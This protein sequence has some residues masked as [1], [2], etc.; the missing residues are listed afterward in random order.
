MLGDDVKE[1]PYLL[2]IMNLWTGDWYENL[3]QMSKKVDEDNGGGGTQ[4]TG[5]F[6]K[7]WGFSRKELCKNI[8]YL[9]SA[10]TFCIGG[11]ILWEKD[12]QISGKKR[13]MSSIQSKVYLY[14]ICA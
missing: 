1:L 5:R 2:M 11:L 7:L 13:K 9:L 14:E 4:E 3:D 8:G 6:W 12:P 10:P